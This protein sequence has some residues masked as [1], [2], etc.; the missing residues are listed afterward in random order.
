MFFI[1]DFRMKP[2]LLI[3]GTSVTAKSIFSYVKDYHLFN[4]L[5]FVVDS[6]FKNNDTYCDKP[7]YTF[8]SIP[9][10]FDKK[11]DFLFVAIEWDRLNATRRLLFERLKKEGFRLANI[12]SPH[13]IIHGELRG[14]NCWIC[15]NVVIENDAIIYDNVFIKTGAIIQHLTI[16]E[17]H[18]FIGAKA[19]MAGGVHIGEQSYIGIG[20]I[21]FN[22]VNIGNKCLVGGATFVKRHLSDFSSIKTKNDVFVINQYDTY[23]IESKLLASIKVR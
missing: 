5:G 22:G 2:Q 14:E 16:I 15:D 4:L 13:A 18:C 23:E 17:S 1:Q 11:N 21:I 6:E 20:A 3:V 10:T 19:Q 12:I 8:D 9:A 7:V